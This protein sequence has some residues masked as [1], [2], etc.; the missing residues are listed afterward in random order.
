MHN[1]G[2]LRA[3]I[4]HH[5]QYYHESTMVITVER[6]SPTGQDMAA[7]SE[8]IVSNA[9]RDLARWLYSW[10]ESDYEWQTSPTVVDEAIIS[11]DYTFTESGQRFG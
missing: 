2:Q 3:T 9:L 8:D 4:R 7:D 5:D 10:L 6:H 1:G 11:G